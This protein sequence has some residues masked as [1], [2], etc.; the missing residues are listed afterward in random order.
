M[1][2]ELKGKQCFIDVGAHIG[3]YS[4]VA[5]T[6][7]PDITVFAFEMD[8][9]TASQLT[10]NVRLNG[11][12]NVEV[13]R[14]AVSDHEGVVAYGCPDDRPFSENRIDP[15]DAA[16][17]AKVGCVT[18][19]AFTNQHGLEPDVLKIDV[20]GAELQVLRGMT[21]VISRF[22]PTIFVEVH[23]EN[24]PLFNSSPRDVEEFLKTRGYEV[25]AVS[26]KLKPDA[27]SN[28]PTMLIARPRSVP[29]ESP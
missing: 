23:P 20:E 14:L 15:R 12:E 25:S 21:D 5:A 18:L 13:Q 29:S 17:S 6:V 3:W 2:Q 26:H 8:E 27:T 28:Q 10:E 19:D 16:D 11:C 9:E 1:I 4:C 22:S 24:M 7:F